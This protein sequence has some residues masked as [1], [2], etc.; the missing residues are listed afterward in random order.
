MVRSIL[1]TL[2]FLAITV[3]GLLWVASTPTSAPYP[4]QFIHPPSSSGLTPTL[5]RPLTLLSYNIAYGRGLLDDKGDL[6][7]RD[8]IEKN[9]D[10][11]I[12]YFKQIDADIIGLQEVDFGA[13]RSHRIDEAQFVLERLG[14]TVAGVETWNKRYVP[15]PLWPIVQH[16]QAVISGQIVAS[17]FSLRH[18]ERIPLPQPAEN[19]FWY[20]R[21]YLTRCLQRVELATEPP[22]T[23]INVHLEAF[24]GKNRL[25]QIPI[26]LNTVSTIKTPL[27]VLG[28]FN[29]LPPSARMTRGFPDEPDNDY[30]G[31][32]SI[33]IFAT[34]SPLTD[35]LRLA[36]IPTFP[37][38]Q[39]TR[40]IDYIFV[41]R[42]WSV[43]DAA[44]DPLE[45]SDHRPI[46]AR[47][48]LQAAA[49]AAA[50]SLVVP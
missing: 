48:T 41:S 40:R 25:E 50:P 15:Y 46:H 5:E 22:V 13:H 37:A 7:S 9:L 32:R 24:S 33:E 12:A 21:F 27:I 17:K 6:R 43:N 3:L 47:L 23:V 2:A 42:H 44:V 26:L 8:T 31:D 49:L 14:Y 11:L 35:V 28:D 20:N 34:Q 10:Q 1:M 29:A 16:Y 4:K 38:D 19:G 36:D 30:T 39:P 45:L 18:Q